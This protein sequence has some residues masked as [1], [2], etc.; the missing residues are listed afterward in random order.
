MFATIIVVGISARAVAQTGSDLAVPAEYIRDL[1]LPGTSNQ[2]LRPARIMVDPVRDE[3]YVA[4][5]GNSRIL[6]FDDRGVLRF[7]FSTAAQCGG[8]IDVA[9]SPEGLIY[10]LGTASTGR[11]I[12][13]YDYDGLYLRT[14]SPVD[15]A[16][17]TTSDISSIAVDA[18]NRLYILDQARLRIL[19]LRDDGTVTQEF[20]VVADV[21]TAQQ[22]ELILGSLTIAGDQ[23]LLPVSSLGMV[24]RYN[25]EG[26][27]RGNIGHGGSGIGE[28]SFPVATAV[29]G[30]GLVMVLDKHRFNV[31]CFSPS[32]KFLGEYGGKGISPGWFYHPT[33][34]AVDNQDQVYIGQIFQN[35]VQVCR[36]PAFIQQHVSGNMAGG[37]VG[38]A[39]ISQ[40]RT[41][42]TVS[43]NRRTN[44]PGED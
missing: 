38:S 31:V 4:D 29:A 30:D 3:I 17:V 8:P 32:G 2:L 27:F 21:D 41:I 19:C 5:V 9:V 14:I 33:W 24:Y 1:T 11:Q 22:A 10:V 26:E 40:T 25:L 34:L 13:V 36:I 37:V 16:R 35:K 23:L 12:F 28:L 39:T 42:N 44:T 15:S 20:P 18:N 43:V 7:E 6:I